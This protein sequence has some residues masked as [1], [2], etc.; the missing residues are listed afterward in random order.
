[1]AKPRL[2][3]APSSTVDVTAPLRSYLGDIS[4]KYG[5]IDQ[6]QDAEKERA[7]ER[8][9]ADK[10]Y[11]TEQARLLDKDQYAQ[12]RDTV[13][14]AYKKYDLAESA[15]RFNAKQA[16]DD[17]K[18]Q[19]DTTLHNWKVKDREEAK[20]N[21]TI[22]NELMDSAFYTADSLGPNVQARIK[23]GRKYIT[24]LT[25]DIDKNSAAINERRDFIT[26]DGGFSPAGKAEYD[27]RFSS[28]MEMYN[29]ANKAAELA[30]ADVVTMRD[31]ALANN[32]ETRARAQLADVQQSFDAALS[33]LPYK[34]SVEEYVAAGIAAAK[35]AGHTNLPAYEKELTARAKNALGLKT[36]AEIVATGQ[37]ATKTA[38]DRQ[39][40]QI[41]LLKKYYDARSSSGKTSSTKS[42]GMSANDFLSQINEL[43]TFGDD[44]K[45][46]AVDL[47]TTLS[48]P[49]NKV[50]EG[51]SPGIL[52]EAIILT[53][54]DNMIFEDS[55]LDPSNPEDLAKVMEVAKA[56]NRGSYSGKGYTVSKDDF[57]IKDIPTYS[58]DELLGRRFDLTVPKTLVTPSRELLARPDVVAFKEKQAAELKAKQEAVAKAQAQKEANAKQQADWAPLKAAIDQQRADILEARK[59]GLTVQEQNA[60]RDK[61]GFQWGFKDGRNVFEKYPWE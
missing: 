60:L 28:Y 40:E 13:E 39:L 26:A 14:D 41:D 43:D 61:Y 12:Y 17:L 50:A 44:E 16:L 45:Q 18:S 51:I 22:S 4:S 31:N 27:A 7:L 25:A 57:K 58:A 10:R 19:Q 2:T 15:R 33:Q 21:L 5:K 8:E 36:R 54:S 56:L 1:M 30:K 52:R 38:Y 55:T 46:Q 20:K 32:Y 23:E 42:K 48:D 53:I 47:F 37:A 34:G 59:D 29:D 24:N 35:K 6:L 9:I 3:S 11:A 49:E